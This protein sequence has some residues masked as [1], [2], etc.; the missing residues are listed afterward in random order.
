MSVA[1]DLLALGAHPDDMDLICG[2]TL[3]KM[4]RA[5]HTT[6]IVDLTAGEMGTRGTPEKRA[7][8]AARAAE[9]L[10]VKLRVNAGLPDAQLKNDDAS[11]KVIVELLRR[12]RPS[13]VI[14]TFPAGRHPDHRIG[15]ELCR[16]ACFFSGLKNYPAE[17]SARRPE[18]IIYALAYRENPVKPTL[19][20]DISDVFEIKMAAI[21]SY[22]TQFDGV[23]SAGELFPTGQDLYDLVRTQ[24]A[25]YGSLIRCAYGEP[26][27]TDETVRIDDVVAM[28]VRSV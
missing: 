11:R 12:F 15:T 6:G 5:G 10:G 28:G 8:E 18:K 20:V 4:H 26:F 2:G 17:G 16:D 22:S 9:I 21:K 25:H 3:A 7:K 19:V 14:L 13:T 1:V 27:Y 24:D 23:H